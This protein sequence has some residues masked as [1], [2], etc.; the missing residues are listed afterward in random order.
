MNKN[1]NEKQGTPPKSSSTSRTR[2]Q[3]IR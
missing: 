3:D 1:F 2:T